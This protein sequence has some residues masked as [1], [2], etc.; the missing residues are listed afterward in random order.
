[1]THESHATP[2]QR[3]PLKRHIVELLPHPTRGRA[4]TA[5]DHVKCASAKKKAAP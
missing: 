5:L 1:M 3:I 2:A 4:V